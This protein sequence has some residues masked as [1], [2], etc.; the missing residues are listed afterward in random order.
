MGVSSIPRQ[1][2]GDGRFLR[3]KRG[4]TPAYLN[5]QEEG[6]LKEKVEEALPH[7]GPSCRVC[8][9]L[10]RGVDRR[11]NRF[12]VCCVGRYAQV[13]SAFPHLGEEDVLRGWMGSGT[14]FFSWCN[15]RCVFCQNYETSQVGDGEEVGPKALA[16]LMVLLQE[17]GCHNIN[18]VTPEHVVPQIVEALPYAIDMGLCLPLVYNTSAYDSLESLRVMDGL[19]DVYMPDFKLWG[20]QPSRRYLL[21]PDYP[22]VAR[23]AIS[24]MHAQVGPLKV[25]EDGLA[26]RGVLVRHL[27]MPGMPEETQR[28]MSWLAA[29]SG[30]TYVNI[31]DQYRPAWKAAGP[32][33]ASINRRVNPEEM[34]RAYEA[35]GEAGLWR[36]DTRWRQA[37][38]GQL[39]R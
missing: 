10:C 36:F 35:A 30:D 5:A 38:F 20:L 1:V 28:I 15:L 11:A 18:F 8:P 2:N 19:V 22:E 24:E 6:R 37:S 25:D 7:L 31:M 4:F 34:A 3:S 33:Y 9:R 23:R 26:L 32:G 39:F 27:V 21:A 12:G 17:R 16:R 14:I 13:A 29:L